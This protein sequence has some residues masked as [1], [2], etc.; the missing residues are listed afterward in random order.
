MKQVL[1]FVHRWLG[2]VFCLLFLLWFPS[3]FVM[4]YWDYPSVTPADS[5]AHR[6]ALDLAT[7][8]LS[9]ADA[10]AKVQ[11]APSGSIHLTTFAGR[12]IYRFGGPDSAVVYADTGDEQTE[13][14]QDEVARIATMWSGQP[15]K[16]AR[17]EAVEHV[18]QWTL[19][20]RIADLQPLW[21][22]SWPDGQQVYISQANGEVIQYT[23]RA[24]RLGAWFGAIPHW[25]YFTPLR[26]NG[27]LWSRVV[28]WSS[29]IASIAA[30]IGLVI[31]VWMY[32]PSKPY[33]RGGAPTSIPYRGW[34]RWHMIVGLVAGAG[35]VTWAFSGMLSMEPFPQRDRPSD[36]AIG[37]QRVLQALRGRAP[38]GRFAA[39]DARAALRQLAGLRVKDLEFTSIAG[40]PAYFA[41]LAGG[42]TRI[43]PV[44]GPPIAGLDSRALVDVLT[45][46]FT[47][48]GHA[49]VSVVD[50]YDRYYLDRHHT[51]PLPVV[52]IEVDD[53]EHTRFYVD[54]KSA[55][56]VGGYS[57]SNFLDRWL[58][59]GLH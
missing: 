10:A 7:V 8:R 44:E 59:H 39:K 13:I 14:S 42:D 43:V 5:L 16:A 4:M 58:Y 6:A 26:R 29:G 31:G 32:S 11:I 34:K 54:P 51:A 12:P 1:I 46:A 19:Q 25:L 53:A 57:A 49:R 17:V 22:F 9:A 24:S 21:K 50:R 48:A 3:G 38:L 35:A 30:L 45:Q 27:P 2:V 33:Q 55:R 15:V 47:A 36:A 20:H 18:D 37:A 28:I 41:T 23:T 52:L 40:E 56:T